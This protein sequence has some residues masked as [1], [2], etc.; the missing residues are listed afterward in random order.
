MEI[1]LYYILPA[2]SIAWYVGTPLSENENSHRKNSKEFSEYIRNITIDDNEVL[3]SFDVTSLYTNV[4]IKDTLAII[5]D[6]LGNDKDLD[7]KTKIPLKTLL[8]IT[9]LLLTRTWFTF[10]GK[11]YSQTD[12]VAMG[13]PASSVVA[14]IYMQ[15]HESTALTTTT[16]GPKLWEKFVDDVFSIIKED[17]LTELRVS[18]T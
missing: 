17:N 13:G 9:E 15:G 8:E 1:E 4:P 10:N 5:R 11:I 18:Y 12:G 3:V 7:K 14:E 2:R 16:S 6:L